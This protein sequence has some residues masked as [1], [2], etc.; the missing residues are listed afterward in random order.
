MNEFSDCY[1]LSVKF[2]SGV[3]NPSWGL[4]GVLKDG[5]IVPSSIIQGAF[6]GYYDFDKKLCDEIEETVIHIPIVKDHWGHFLI[7][8]LCRFWFINLPEFK[9][10]TITCCVN[11]KTPD[12]VGNFLHVFELLGVADRLR[13]ITKPT[14]CKKLFIPDYSLGFNRSWSN[15]YL[16]VIKNLLL[17]T[18]LNNKYKHKKVYFT[19]TRFL[20]SRIFEIGEKQIEKAFRKIGFEILSPEKMSIEEQILCFQ[21]ADEIVSLSG[22]IPHNI[23]FARDGLRFTILNRQPVILLPQLRINQM[24]SHVQIYYVDVWHPIMKINPKPYGRGGAWIYISQKLSDYFYEK[25][26]VNVKV[27]NSLILF[28]QR[29]HWCAVQLF[30]YIWSKR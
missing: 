9:N 4:G 8:V 23:V 21:E 3:E 7:D 16:E 6:G 1:I 13:L 17:K 14:H 22:T 11:L 19:R 30:D 26:S 28:F 24:M 12:I 20:K 29:L 15:K 18:P 5:N 27:T 25:Y 10:F 2:V